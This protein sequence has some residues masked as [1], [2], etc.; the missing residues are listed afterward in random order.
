MSEPKMEVVMTLKTQ[1]EGG[2]ELV[3][4]T[5]ALATLATK[6][7]T[8]D[9]ALAAAQV[10]IKS[11]GLR[12]A[13]LTAEREKWQ[14]AVKTLQSECDANAVLTDELAAVTAERDALRLD[15]ARYA[16]LRKIL[17]D[18]DI[19]RLARHAWGTSQ[20]HESVRVDRKIDE[21]MLSSKMK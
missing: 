20:E 21:L 16:C 18:D 6:D 5:D 9:K 4:R 3:R 10:V 2:V 7:A 1:L 13:A 8:H 17:D 15:A 12:L 11:Q 19:E 14:E